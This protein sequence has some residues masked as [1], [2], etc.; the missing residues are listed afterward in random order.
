MDN[1]AD[2]I[3]KFQTKAERFETKK[4]KLIDSMTQIEANRENIIN[5]LK[6]EERMLSQ[7]YVLKAECN[8][9][10]K[11]YEV[12]PN[13]AKI[14]MQRID[15]RIEELETVIKKNNRTKEEIDLLLRDT[16]QFLK[17]HTDEE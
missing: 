8:E 15:L 7:L 13:D 11:V 10:A 4:N 16:D 1:K 6:D 17:K 12:I 3:I 9:K 14:L 5:E 2:N